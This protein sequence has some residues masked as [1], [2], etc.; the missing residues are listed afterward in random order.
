M[1]SG[2]ET[3]FTK[4]EPVTRFLRRLKS[5]QD[6][7]DCIY[8]RSHLVK[9]AIIDSGIYADNKYF[10]ALTGTSFIEDS[11]PSKSS[12]DSHWH[13]PSN[14]HGTKM[15]LLVKS[16]N[17]FCCFHAHKVHNNVG[18]EGGD[19]PTLIKVCTGLF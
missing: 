5:E 13:I 15:A 4:M 1:H 19:I 14:A 10:P 17:P 2:K 18:K 9:V 3:I 12:G 11:T 16:L 8:L 6:R 7:A